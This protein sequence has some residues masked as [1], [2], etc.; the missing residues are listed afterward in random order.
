MLLVLAWLYKA[1]PL[2]VCNYY[3]LEEQELLGSAYLVLAVAVLIAWLPRLFLG[4]G[5]GTTARPGWELAERR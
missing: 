2:R 4:T 3:L 1:A 5:F